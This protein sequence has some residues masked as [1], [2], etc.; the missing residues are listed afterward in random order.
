MELENYEAFVPVPEDWWVVMTD[1]KGSTQ[2]I[3]EGRYKDVNAIGA[4][5]ITAVI[6]AL[7]RNE[8]AYVF[9]GDGAT[10]LIPGLWKEAALSALNGVR[11]LAKT[12]FNLDLRVGAVPVSEIRKLG[13]EV[14]VCCYRVTEGYRQALFFG[15][16]ID[17]AEH[18]I[19]E[20]LQWQTAED[21]LASAD[22]SG[23]ECRWDHVPGP[24]GEVVALLVKILEQNPEKSLALYREVIREI[25]RV[26][27]VD[28]S[29]NPLAGADLRT[30]LSPWKLRIEYSINRASS[31]NKVAKSFLSLW[32]K[33]LL[34]RVF[35]FSERTVWPM[36][37][38][39]YKNIVR[40]NADYRKFDDM[41]R[42]LLSGDE[43]QRLSLR[44]YLEEKH[45]Q[46]K[47]AFGIYA[48][49][50]SLIT[51]MVLERGNRHCH[52]ID[53]SNGGY[54]MAA[55][56]LKRQLNALKKGR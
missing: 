29:G 12:Y 15:G 5:S 23:F 1:V 17:V 35:E 11:N 7:N 22:L 48:S 54:A 32:F 52:F 36:T 47:L 2:A 20:N 46:G 3:N 24:R 55:V 44:S 40:Q 10:F 33:A 37:W 4:A 16:G 21:A 14:A 51:C 38:T 41:L 18:L 43:K 50:E 13:A 39:S 34:G 8:I 49:P 26:Y 9:G 56:E 30:T 42:L 25:N 45:A 6:N 28:A 53:G 31:S 27:A 19:K